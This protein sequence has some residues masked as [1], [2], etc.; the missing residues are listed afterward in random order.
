MTYDEAMLRYGSDKPDLRFGL[1]IADLGHV[2]EG[3][4][5]GVFRGVLASGKLARAGVKDT[6][7]EVEAFTRPM[8]DLAIN[9]GVTYANARNRHN[10]VGADGAPLSN[11]LWQLSGRQ[12]S[13]APRWTWL[14]KSQ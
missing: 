1:E 3:T 4:E 10:L 11:A 6:G 14:L 5:F 8:P 13:N 9:G 7:F 2:F 12:I